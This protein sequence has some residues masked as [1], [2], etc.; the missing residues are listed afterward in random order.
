ME[1]LIGMA[2]GAGLVLAAA[3]EKK[4]RARR[5]EMLRRMQRRHT[6]KIENGAV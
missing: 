5:R 4:R 3:F 2:L 1:Y 6:W